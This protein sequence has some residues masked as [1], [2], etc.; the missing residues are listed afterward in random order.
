MQ[1]SIL[2]NKNEFSLNCSITEEQFLEISR[3]L[4]S[5]NTENNHDKRKTSPQSVL[6]D[7]LSLLSLLNEYQPISNV[8]KIAVFAFYLSKQSQDSTFSESELLELFKKSNFKIPGNFV[9]DLLNA[10]NRGLIFKVK[11]YNDRFICN[12]SINEELELIK[13]KKSNRKNL[14]KKKPNQTV[15]K[16]RHLNNDLSNISISAVTKNPKIYFNKLTNGALRILWII[17]FLKESGFNSTSIKDIELI[18]SKLGSTILSKHFSTLNKE[19]LVEARVSRTGNSFSILEAG[20]EYL[21]NS[22]K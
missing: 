17:Y 11:E 1:L 9:R 4:V 10:V 3:I 7:T 22:A 13:G 16:K 14:L 15:S 6:N 5:Q 21:F 18:S 12:P 8:D 19:N 20:E 2:S